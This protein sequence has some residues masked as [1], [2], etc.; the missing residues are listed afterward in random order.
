M[1][2]AYV[3]PHYLRFG[4]GHPVRTAEFGLVPVAS[5]SSKPGQRYF[6][7][8]VMWRR[9]GEVGLRL[10]DSAGR[11]S[12]KTLLALCALEPAGPCA[13]QKAPARD[14]RP[15][16]RNHG[17]AGLSMLGDGHVSDGAGLTIS[18]RRTDA[19]P[20][21]LAQ[22]RPQRHS[23][24]RR[25]LGLSVR[26]YCRLWALAAASAAPPAPTETRTTPLADAPARARA[27]IGPARQGRQGSGARRCRA[28]PRRHAPLRPTRCID[29]GFSGSAERLRQRDRRPCAALPGYRLAARESAGTQ[30]AASRRLAPS[31]LV[32]SFSGAGSWVRQSS[33]LR[34]RLSLSARRVQRARSSLPGLL[35]QLVDA[36]S[37][38][39]SAHP[40]PLLPGQVGGRIPVLQALREPIG[41]ALAYLIGA[42]GS[43]GFRGAVLRGCRW[44]FLYANKGFNGARRGCRSRRRR[45]FLLR[46]SQGQ[47]RTAGNAQRERADIQQL[48]HATPRGWLRIWEGSPPQASPPIRKTT[49]NR[50]SGFL[51]ARFTR[52]PGAPP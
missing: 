1:A 5:S 14:L 29:R 42:I 10:I 9:P 25:R 40:L 17:P 35:Q 27:K 37:G 44:V 48:A 22:S 13:A 6:R 11:T 51:P 46:L 8:D 26:I 52:G 19:R 23:D 31:G 38:D 47:G 16:P 45:A 28:A 41:A 3:V 36:L 32:C 50:R 20:P 7:C 39:A 33:P 15:T 12:R 21:D 43:A 30:D 18:R 2:C 34:P 24:P 4:I 49:E